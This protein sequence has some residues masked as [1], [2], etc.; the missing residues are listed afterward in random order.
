MGKIRLTLFLFL[1]LHLGQC[2][3]Q[4]S[5]SGFWQTP[6]RSGLYLREL[7]NGLEINGEPHIL[8]Q[9]EEGVHKGTSTSYTASLSR[10]PNGYRLTT[11]TLQTWM[12]ADHINSGFHVEEDEYRISADGQYLLL[13]IVTRRSGEEKASSQSLT[14]RRVATP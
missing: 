10:V 7:P 12:E 9:A 6:T 4:A 3:A 5:L 1:A 14:F 13:T 11:R 2:V 8:D